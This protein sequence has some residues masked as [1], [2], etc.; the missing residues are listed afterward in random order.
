MG[1][2][3]RQRASLRHKGAWVRMFGWII[4]AGAALLLGACQ[5]QSD[6]PRQM[7]FHA[8]ASLKGM[9]TCLSQDYDSAFPRWFP[10]RADKNSK[11]FQTYNNMLMTVSKSADG[12]RVEIFSSDELTESQRAYIEKCERMVAAS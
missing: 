3:E 11:S 7:D 10:A 4:G 12:S 8:H 2:H 6:H 1:M 5:A 9:V